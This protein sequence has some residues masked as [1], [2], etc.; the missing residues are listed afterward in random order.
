MMFM[1]T[2]V[3]KK[4]EN[5]I[6]WKLIN[7]NLFCISWELYYLCMLKIETDDFC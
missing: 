1:G 5:S 4:C 6:I 3:R 2:K 7:I